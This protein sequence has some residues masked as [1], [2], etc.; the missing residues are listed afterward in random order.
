MK[1]K[2]CLENYPM[3]MTV[4]DLQGFIEQ[5]PSVAYSVTQCRNFPAIRIGN[6]VLIYRDNF[7][8]WLEK[9]GCYVKN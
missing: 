7:I 8:K 4:K 3:I 5:S 2:S 9:S 1:D 6:R